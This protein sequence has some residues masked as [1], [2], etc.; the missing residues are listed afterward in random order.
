MIHVV[1]ELRTRI[2]PAWRRIAQELVDAGAN[3]VL[4]HGQ[5]IPTRAR[6]LTAADGR[7]AAVAYGLGNFVSDMG[8]RAR[9][10]RDLPDEPDKWDLPQT[11]EALVARVEL[12]DGEVRT[13]FL[14]VFVTST[15][16]LV[17]N[18]VLDG[19]VRYALT[20]LSACGSAIALPTEWPEPFRS[21]IRAWHDERRDHL[22]EVTGLAS[23]ECEPGPP[24]PL[25]P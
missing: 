3:A 16:Y 12:S 17:Y 21:D 6:T 9:P 10:E 18:R 25:R 2:K 20:P 15:N 22:L 19:P 8:S 23:T 7:A 14:P 5:H 11:R 4:F 1:Y 13:S 24:H